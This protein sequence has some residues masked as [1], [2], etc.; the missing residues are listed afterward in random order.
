M[1]NLLAVIFSASACVHLY[2]ATIDE[3]SS[4]IVRDAFALKDSKNWSLESRLALKSLNT[5]GRTVPSA[6][7]RRAI[8]SGVFSSVP[9]ALKGRLQQLADETERHEVQFAKAYA[10]LEDETRTALVSSDDVKL[11]ES[12]SERWN[13]LQKNDL[14]IRLSDHENG[15]DPYLLSRLIQ[16]TLVVLQQLEIKELREA[17]AALGEVFEEVKRVQASGSFTREFTDKLHRLYGKLGVLS[18]ADLEKRLGILAAKALE[19]AEPSDIDESLAE[20]SETVKIL[21]A[22]PFRERHKTAVAT[23]GFLEEWQRFLMSKKRG[24]TQSDGFAGLSNLNGVPGIR[25]SRVLE[26]TMLIEKPTPFP[27]RPAL[28]SWHLAESGIK[29]LDDLNEKIPKTQNFNDP[30]S[31]RILA[32]LREINAVYQL[33]KSSGAIPKISNQPTGEPLVEILRANVVLFALSKHLET[34]AEAS[35]TPDSF[36]NR[37]LSAAK[38]ANDWTKSLKLLELIAKFGDSAN[39]ETTRDI[40]AL[41][42]FLGARNYEKTNLYTLAVAGYVAALKSGVDFLPSSE[43]AESLGKIKKASPEEYTKG[44]DYSDTVGSREYQQR[45]DPALRNWPTRSPLPRSIQE[46]TL[47]PNGSP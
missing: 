39:P 9:K 10:A 35:D 21:A 36:L 3:L 2:S 44:L 7:L 22:T 40:S 12:L 5:D 46:G 26:K 23:R 32:A 16:K 38:K 34:T 4:G 41:Q 19:T 27:G 42:H 25:R 33:A 45:F 11:L 43:I 15:H 28:T 18:E 17:R 14:S 37:Q 13:R 47:R 6:S 1:K 24:G 29:T 8:D 30:E 20:A 31:M